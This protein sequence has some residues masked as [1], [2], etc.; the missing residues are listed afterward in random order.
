MQTP[1][2][3][4]ETRRHLVHT[5]KHTGVIHILKYT[6][7]WFTHRTKTRVVHILKHVVHILKRIY[8]IHPLKHTDMWFTH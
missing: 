3:H 5:P 1:G 6:D 4:T 8:V 7:T 2:S